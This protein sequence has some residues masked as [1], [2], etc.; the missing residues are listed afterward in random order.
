MTKHLYLEA[1]RVLALALAALLV[2]CSVNPPK[3]P[4]CDGTDRRAI[5]SSNPT[6]AVLAPSKSCPAT[7]PGALGSR[8]TG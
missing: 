2:G 7:P 3:P 1:A 4:R 8:D 5:N 6:L